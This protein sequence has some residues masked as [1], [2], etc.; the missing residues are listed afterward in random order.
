MANVG[1]DGRN[2]SMKYWSVVLF[3]HQFQQLTTYLFK[4]PIK[5]DSE[6]HEGK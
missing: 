3:S 5:E 4:D 2:D 1:D 6:T